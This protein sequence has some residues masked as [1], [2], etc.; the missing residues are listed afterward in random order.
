MG[1]LHLG[2][3]PLHASALELKMDAPPLFRG[4]PRGKGNTQVAFLKEVFREGADIHLEDD[5]LAHDGEYT[6]KP[7][8]S[9]G[10]QTAFRR[11][12]LCLI[13]TLGAEH[14]ASRMRS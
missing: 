2:P 6:G 11:T 10:L 4:F 14:E 8:G 12:M 13:P 1:Q 5:F 3:I 9:L 7:E